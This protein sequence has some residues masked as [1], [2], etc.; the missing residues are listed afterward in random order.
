[1]EPSNYSSDTLRIMERG[2][3]CPPTGGLGV[4]DVSPSLYAA[5]VRQIRRQWLSS[6]IVRCNLNGSRQE[7]SSWKR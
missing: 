6:S 5:I 1:M 4:E 2:H 7:E 3:V